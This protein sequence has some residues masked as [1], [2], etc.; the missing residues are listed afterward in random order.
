[1]EHTGKWRSQ[2]RINQ[3]PQYEGPT[4]LPFEHIAVVVDGVKITSQVAPVIRV[5]L[6]KVDAQRFYTK[7]A[8]WVCGS[9]RSRLGWSNETFDGVHWEALAQ[10]LKYKPDSF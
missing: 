2:P 7:V 5:A 1:M 10:A 8:D 6:G 3:A 9:N 4:L